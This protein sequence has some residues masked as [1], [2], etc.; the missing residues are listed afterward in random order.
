MAVASREEQKTYLKLVDGEELSMSRFDTGGK[1]IE[2][3]LKGFIY[4]ERGVWRPGDTL[5]VTFILEDREKRIPDTHPVS[6][7]LYTPQ[8][9]FYARQIASKGVN[10]FYT[11]NIETHDN[12][13]TGVWNSYVKVGGTSFHKPLRIETVKPNRLKIQVKA[14]E[15]L[16]ASAQEATITLSSSWLTGATASNLKTDMELSLHRVNTQFSGYS[17]YTFNDP[18]SKF[19][20]SK[21]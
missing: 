3:G 12:D 17:N 7:E 13:P 11:F 6:L 8:G 5:H 15:R 10:G 2:K 21:E 4:G 19:E 9:Q 18:A 1:S 20:S 14:P 16:E